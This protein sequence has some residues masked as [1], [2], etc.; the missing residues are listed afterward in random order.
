MKLFLCP[1]T[2][3]VEQ[4]TNGGLKPVH[5]PSMLIADDGTPFMMPIAV[6]AIEVFVHEMDVPEDGAIKKSGSFI[7]TASPAVRAVSSANVNVTDVSSDEN[8]VAID[9]ADSV[10]FGGACRR[11]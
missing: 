8:G 3:V 4:W 7:T 5:M 10:N 1:Q 6:V 11:L 2:N 9:S